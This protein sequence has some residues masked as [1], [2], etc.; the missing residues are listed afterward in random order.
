MPEERQFN[1]LRVGSYE[2]ALRLGLAI[3]RHVIFD[4]F[5]QYG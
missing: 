4:C 3:H 1:S 5:Q 2:L